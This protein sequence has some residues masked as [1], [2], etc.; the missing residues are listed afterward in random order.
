M[1]DDGDKVTCLSCG[2]P[3]TLFQGSIDG[4][5]IGDGVLFYKCGNRQYIGSVNRVTSFGVK[6]WN[7][8][9]KNVK[10]DGF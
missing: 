3:H 6:A 7:T 2:K 5:R 10:A 4:I 1:V 8:I 9:Q